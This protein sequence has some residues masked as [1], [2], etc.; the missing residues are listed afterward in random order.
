MYCFA[1][2]SHGYLGLSPGLDFE[3]RILFKPNAAELL[4]DELAKKSYRCRPMALGTNT[5]PYQPVERRLRLTRSILE[6][7]VEHRHPVGIVT[8]SDLVT[9]DLDLLAPMAR[10][11]RASVLFSITTLDRR[12]ARTMEPRAATPQRRLDAMAA[13]SR[14]GVPTGVLASPMIPALNDCE[15]ETI[16]GAAA[17][18][19][20]GT[21]GYMLLRL[22][23]EL[24]ELFTDWLELH[25]PTKATK[26]LNRLREMRGGRLYDARFGL[27]QIGEGR[28]AQLLRRRFEIA[29][30]RLGL[31]LDRP[32][33]DCSRFG[34]PRRRQPSLFG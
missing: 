4:R 24:Q 25:Y 26:V 19:G 30:R 18:A 7:L 17:E 6:V 20:A 21:A 15:L 23:H 31:G 27:R 9:R 8:K 34:V 32:R 3:S 16:L 28:H 2:P 11:N 22:P 1:R 33:L 12:L 5:D 13:V 29:C 10:E 14:A